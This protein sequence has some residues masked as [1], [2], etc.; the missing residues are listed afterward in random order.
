MSVEESADVLGI[1]RNLFDE[2][3]KSNI[4]YCHFKSNQHVVEGLCGN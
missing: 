1:T 4:L 2:W 3:E